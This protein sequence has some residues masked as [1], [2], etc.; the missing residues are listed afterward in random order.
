MDKTRSRR[1]WLTPCGLDCSQC[2]IHL[3]TDE[4]LDYWRKKNVDPDK[5]RCDGCRSDR[6]GHHWSPDCKILQCCVDGRGLEFCARCPDFPCRVLEEW[7]RKYDHHARAVK[8][9]FK[10]KETGIDNWIKEHSK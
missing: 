5:I 9:L 10:M 7:A 3:R 1:W 6:E 4:E 8:N 2:S